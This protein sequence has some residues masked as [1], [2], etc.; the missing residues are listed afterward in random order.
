MKKIA[1][2]AGPFVG[3]I[4]VITIFS[5]MPEVSDRFLNLANIKSVATQSVIV[6]L[7][8]LGM[9]LIIVSGG[10]DLSAASNLALSCVL[11]AYAI[12]LGVP[13]L[14]AA[15]VG[16]A[17]GGTIGFLNGFLITRLR[18]VPFIVTLGMMGI[19]R[20]LAKWVARNQKIDA[21]LSWLNELMVRTS[22]PSWLLVSPGIW[23]MILFSLV[24]AVLLRK[25]VFGRHAFAVGSNELTARLC[26]VRTD[27]VKVVVYTI[28]GLLCGLAGVME[29]SRLTVGDPT[30]AMGLE[31]D[32]IAAVVIGGGS[33]S[34]GE[35]S[36]LG[37]L[38]GVFIMAF[39]RNGCTMM[40]WPNYFQEIIIGAIII[41]AVTLDRLR[42]RQE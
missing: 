31:L 18:L 2:L 26:G 5:L 19:A 24:M 3:L 21:P 1:G 41:A 40:G 35:G 27:R 9:T 29:F 12:N 14:L 15:L 34:G 23:L 8:A 30:V 7:C 10:I 36:I 22:K 6:A 4:L 20:G 13:P 25:T 39:L 38:V 32:I 42:H 28:S 11:V 17:A 37:T 16:V 33:L